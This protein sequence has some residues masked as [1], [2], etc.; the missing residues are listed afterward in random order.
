L[1]VDIIRSNKEKNRRRFLR[2][3]EKIR[4]IISLMEEEGRRAKAV[5]AAADG[6]V[7]EIV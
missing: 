5:A 1:D 7:L 4:I 6:G 3:R 2:E